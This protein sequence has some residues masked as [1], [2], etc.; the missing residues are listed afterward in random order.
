M[1][2]MYSGRIAGFGDKAAEAQLHFADVTWHKIFSR[3]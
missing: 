3:S 1:F 2:S